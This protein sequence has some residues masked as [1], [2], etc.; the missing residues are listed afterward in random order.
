MVWIYGGG[1]AMGEATRNLYSPDY[2]M[3]KDIVVVTFN[4]R[5]CSLGKFFFFCKLIRGIPFLSC[6]KRIIK[7]NVV[8]QKVRKCSQ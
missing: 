8:E 7:R 1:F 6:A 3:M 5:L 4:Y 2:F